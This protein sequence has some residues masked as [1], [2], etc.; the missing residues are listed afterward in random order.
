MAMNLPQAN[1]AL[2][3]LASLDMLSSWRIQAGGA[4][5]NLHQPATS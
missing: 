5:K 1:D 3:L 2:S 4:Y